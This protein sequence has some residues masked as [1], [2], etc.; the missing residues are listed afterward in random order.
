MRIILLA[1]LILVV[2]DAVALMVISHNNYVQDHRMMVKVETV[3][4]DAI[5]KGNHFPKSVKY[6]DIATSGNATR[7]RSTAAFKKT[8]NQRIDID[9]DHFDTYATNDNTELHL[10]VVKPIK[11]KDQKGKTV[12]DKNYWHM[13]KYVV[14]HVPHDIVTLSL[15][16][17]KKFYY[18][19]YTLNAGPE[20]SDDLWRY[21]PKTQKFKQICEIDGRRVVKIQELR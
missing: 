8:E 21:N 16:K 5:V 1:A 15:F 11:L 6:Y 9:A 4:D 17:T 12:S 18:F 13:I 14:K 10:K 19:Y 20:D 3:P 2:I 7:S